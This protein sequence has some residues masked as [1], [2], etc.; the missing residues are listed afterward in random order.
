MPFS[1][2]NPHLFRRM[3]LMISAPSELERL[4]SHHL[5]AVRARE[6]EQERYERRFASSVTIAEEEAAR[7]PLLARQKAES[8]ASHAVRL[9]T[10]TFLRTGV[11]DME[12][13][14]AKVASKSKSE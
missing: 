11:V 8:K 13:I 12:S 7:M 3:K 9:A 4:K 1:K 6:R 10:E 5:I 14:H 2:M